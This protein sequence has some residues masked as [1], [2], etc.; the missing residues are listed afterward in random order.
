MRRRI[1]LFL[2][3]IGALL[4]AFWLYQ[5]VAGGALWRGGN[6]KAPTAAPTA[7][8]NEESPAEDTVTSPVFVQRSERDGQIEAIYGAEEW[9]R[10]DDDSFLLTRPYVHMFQNGRKRMAISADSGT[11]HVEELANDLKPR[12]GT[13]TGKVH[14]VYDQSRLGDLDALVAPEDLVTVDLDEISYN[15]DLLEMTS[16]SIVRVRSWQADIDGH[17]LDVTW[18]D[19][20][21]E[22]RRLT[23]RDGG[24][25]TV[26][27]LADRFSVVGLP[28]GAA[29][30]VA[31]D[32]GAR[33]AGADPLR[34]DLTG[35]EDLASSWPAPA[36]RPGSIPPSAPASLPG[37]AVSQDEPTTSMPP[38]RKERNVYRATFNRNVHVT[39]GRQSMDGGDKLS[40]LFEFDQEKEF[41]EEAPEQS[42]P[43]TEPADA[44]P[45]SPPEPRQVVVTWS[46]PMVL[47]TVGRT[48]DPSRDRFT[49]EANGEDMVLS[50]ADMTVRGCDR[51]RYDSPRQTGRLTAGSDDV[52]LRMADGTEARCPAVWFDG[53]RELA[54]LAGP[55]V[56]DISRA[57]D[58]A[59]LGSVR[60]GAESLP[61][62][63]AGAATTA[64]SPVGTPATTRPAGGRR[65]SWN[66]RVIARI[67]RRE[68]DSAKDKSPGASIREAVILGKA[69]MED[70]GSG[71]SVS[72]DVLHL[73]LGEGPEG[74]PYPVKFLAE[75]L[76]AARSVDGDISARTVQASFEMA[77]SEAD[78]KVLRPRE[79]QVT[80]AGDVVVNVRDKDQ[81]TTVRADK[82]VVNSPDPAKRWVEVTGA[83]ASIV[84]GDSR[85]TGKTI[86]LYEESGSI[87]VDGPGTLESVTL[88]GLDGQ[89]L[90]NP[91]PV[92]MAWM[93]SMNYDGQEHL[94]VL[95]GDVLV[96]SGWS[97]INAPHMEV[98]LVE[99]DKARQ[100]PQPAADRPMPFDVSGF[101][102]MQLAEVRAANGAKVIYQTR[103]PADELTQEMMLQAD[104]LTYDAAFGLIQCTGQGV[105]FMQDLRPP[106]E[107]KDGAAGLASATV[108]DAAGQIDR[109]WQTVFKW[110]DGMEL[111]RLSASTTVLMR[112][113]VQMKHVS[114]GDVQ[115]AD[116]VN[117]PEWGKLPPGRT[118]TLDGGSLFAEFSK[119]KTGDDSAAGLSADVPFSPGS[120]VGEI[121]SFLAS[122]DVT[123][124]DGEYRLTGQHLSY[125]KDKGF[126][127]LWGY[128]PGRPM[129]NA[130]VTRGGWST[131]SPK[132]IL[133]LD[134]EG[135]IIRAKAQKVSAFGAQ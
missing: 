17:G 71:E 4:G 93:V 110:N 72:G 16:D 41:Q 32:A 85:V 81:L 30:D 7:P 11:V 77:P 2:F 82:V 106:D 50:D 13:L 37:Q 98:K 75:G 118:V 76:A 96:K 45:A 100:A 38:R 48:E 29:T 69:A 6:A 119:A 88:N 55:G 89:P 28:G 113:D 116:D 114:G 122:S 39:S 120:S 62:T 46:G 79:T 135:H 22:L 66:D 131:P 133:Y 23:I 25:M 15:N 21:K 3:T 14:L 73:W 10:R 129:E 126:G 47:E 44:S 111:K 42:E 67:A 86:R 97:S 56:I 68:G 12:R 1:I 92:E 51:F 104:Q 125:D 127:V 18:N 64:P 24:T 33:G 26:K 36:T 58:L 78:P 103:G 54:E 130:V 112:G 40:L 80:A 109:P 8:A 94:A 53:G 117:A 31:S 35:S 132:F 99:V 52:V 5:F 83:P 134:S 95:D 123:L 19:D 84:S 60:V 108:T 102:R 65:V 49:V 63:A 27:A 57:S 91:Q 101:R 34:E 121:K 70:F 59:S 107:T 43:R 115:R 74:R 87:F 90:D 61:A 20:P 128:D 9:T 105:L 124:D